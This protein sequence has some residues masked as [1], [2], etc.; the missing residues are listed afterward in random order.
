[1]STC[2]VWP[3]ASGMDVSVKQRRAM[4]DG[5]MDARNVMVA[6]VAAENV[7][8]IDRLLAGST[9]RVSPRRLRESVMPKHATCFGTVVRGESPLLPTLERDAARYQVLWPCG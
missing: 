9:S 8:T 6:V 3:R 7:C 5:G 1:M 2:T 4:C